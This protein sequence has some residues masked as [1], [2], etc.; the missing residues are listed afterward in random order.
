MAIIAGIDEAGFGPTLGP[1]VVSGVLFRVADADVDACLW[2]MLKQ[3]ITPRVASVSTSRV[4]KTPASAGAGNNGSAP[5]AG[6]SGSARRP[7]RLRKLAI[8]DSKKLFAGRKS[9]GP[10]ERA[11]LV[12]LR[13]GGWAPESLSGLLSTVSPGA[14]D[15]AAVYPWYAGQDFPLPL[16]DD[17]GDVPTRATPVRGNMKRCG[18]ALAGVTC[19]V[20]LEGE[21]NQTLR[22]TRNKSQTVVDIVLRIIDRVFRSAGDE[23]VRV[24][25][26]RLGGREHYLPHLMRAF[27][28]HEYG[29][30]E[31]C[32]ARSIYELRAGPVRRRVEFHINGEDVAMPTA[33]ASVYSKY[34]RELFMH[35]FNRYWTG[36]VPDVHPT[37]GY[38]SDAQRFLRQID[39][40]VRQLG[41]NRAILVRD[42]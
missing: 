2:T 17:T 5:R 11:A 16:A 28:G 4:G 22:Q 40:A 7:G 13:A 19:E 1:L 20:V 38:Y 42:R 8:A 24:V 9:L 18:V 12:M 10:L 32:E 33:L 25:V 34:V 27:D 15:R 3:S 6:R 37:A 29:I 31:E 41:I 23:P 21:Y 36:Q 39:P 26:D 35:A 30:V 14:F